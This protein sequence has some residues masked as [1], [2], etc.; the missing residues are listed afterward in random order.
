MHFAMKSIA[1]EEIT[2]KQLSNSTKPSGKHSK[3]RFLS[4][5]L[6]F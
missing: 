4:S 5:P 3:N 2:F 1:S 6:A